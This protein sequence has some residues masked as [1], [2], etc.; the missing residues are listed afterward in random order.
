M[1]KRSWI[2]LFFA[3]AFILVAAPAFSADDQEPIYG[4]QLMTKQ[5]RIEFR[6][7]MH[8]AQTAEEREQLRLDH[9]AQMQERAKEKGL[10]LP[11]EPTRKGAGM[12]SGRG[13]GPGGGMG[14]GS[15][16]G[17]GTGKGMER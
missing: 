13:M 4:S 9:H 6:Q 10:T 7:K 14:Y 12:G 1:K 11:D 3:M 5:E 2:M 8:N 16:K 15:G 17:A